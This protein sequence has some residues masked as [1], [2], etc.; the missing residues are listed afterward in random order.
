M[1]SIRPVHVRRVAGSLDR[2]DDERAMPRTAAIGDDAHDVG[3][4]YEREGP[5]LVASRLRLRPGPG[6][7][8]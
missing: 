5:R 1:S 2:S 7:H 8:G 4:L 3:D 6:G